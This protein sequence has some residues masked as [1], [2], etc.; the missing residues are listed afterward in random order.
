MIKFFKLMKNSETEDVIRVWIT[1]TMTNWKCQEMVKLVGETEYCAIIDCPE[2]AVY[3]KFCFIQNK[4]ALPEWV[5]DPE[6]EIVATT[7]GSKK[8]QA[9][10]ITIT[11]SDNDV[12]AALNVDSFSVEN[13]SSDHEE[14]EREKCD[15]IWTQVKPRY[16]SKS[17]P[18]EKGPPKLPPHLHQV[19]LDKEDLYIPKT[20]PHR[21]RVQLP[22]PTSHVILNHLCAQA[23]HD[24][25]LVLASTVRYKKKAVTI[26]YY[27]DVFLSDEDEEDE[28]YDADNDD[29][30]DDD[31]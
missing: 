14:E 20:K 15:N 26:V 9:N 8:V 19:L 29:E 27:K 16:S 13:K 31:G 10:V 1:G 12:F 25:V 6:Q 17:G 5:V 28:K 22:E 3:Y 2:G 21:E 18:E 4:N 11:K 24:D 23:K 7:N 30:E